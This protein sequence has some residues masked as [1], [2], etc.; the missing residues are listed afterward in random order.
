MGEAVIFGSRAF[1]L[2]L[3]CRSSRA[4]A[5]HK[6]SRAAVTDDAVLLYLCFDAIAA[7]SEP[8]DTAGETCTKCRF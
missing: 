6:S 4:E 5:R 7:H 8:T 1:A 3:R 2:I